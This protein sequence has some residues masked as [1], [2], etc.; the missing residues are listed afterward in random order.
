[1]NGA[2]IA[3]LTGFTMGK[4]DNAFAV[5]VTKEILSLPIKAVTGELSDQ[6]RAALDK[7]LYD[8][9]HAKDPYETGK[10]LIHFMEVA[11]P[12]FAPE[13]LTR[14]PEIAVECPTLAQMY[15]P[16]T[17]NTGVT[18]LG[19]YPDYVDL[20]N[21]IMA[22]RFEIPPEAWK[23][24]MPEAQWTANVKLLDRT[25][26]RGDTIVLSNNAHSVNPISYFVKEILYLQKKGYSIYADGFSMIPQ[27]KV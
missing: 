3:P 4:E 9:D 21:E 1:M 22:R 12:L 14:N 24:M 8:L 11:A 15:K 23:A 10:A 13:F 19:R 20:S 6:F 27:S 25:I 2:V 16:A 7:A 26:A 18:V 5:N 17:R